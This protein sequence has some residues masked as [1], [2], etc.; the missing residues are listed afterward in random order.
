M[1]MGFTLLGLFPYH[2]GQTDVGNWE[3]SH[4]NK[5]FGFTIKIT[6]VVSFMFIIFTSPKTG[7][8]Q[9]LTILKTNSW[10]AAMFASIQT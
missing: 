3:A 5:A 10:A 9:Y 6:T 2:G 7:G 1:A 8:D 4:E